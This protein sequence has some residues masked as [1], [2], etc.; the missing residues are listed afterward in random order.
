LNFTLS[1]SEY[2]ATY[3]TANP[4]TF[5]HETWWLYCGLPHVQL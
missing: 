4:V 1:V 5:L 2:V 3:V